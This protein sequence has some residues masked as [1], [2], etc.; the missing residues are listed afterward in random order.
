MNVARRNVVAALSG[1]VFAIG[2]GLSGMTQPNKVVGFLDFG[3]DW[4]PSLALVMAGGIGVLLLAQW[5]ARRMARPLFADSFP[6]L[7]RNEIDRR[8]VAGAAIFGVGWGLGGFCPG[9][10]LTSCGIG[11]RAALVFVPAM[12]AGFGAVRLWDAR[13]RLAAEDETGLVE[14]RQRAQP[15]AGS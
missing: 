5:A 9:P 4:D 12:F 14:A 15:V 13:K 2:L 6:V 3:G 1:F 11:T 10:A 7:K 8:L